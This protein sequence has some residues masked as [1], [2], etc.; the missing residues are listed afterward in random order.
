MEVMVSAAPHSP[1]ETQ[2]APA[3]G[4][5]AKALDEVVSRLMDGPSLSPEDERNAQKKGWRKGN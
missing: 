2:Y 4:F 5:D 1:D 3:S